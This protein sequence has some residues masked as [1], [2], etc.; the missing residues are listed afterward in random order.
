MGL[1]AIQ[2][3]E[4]LAWLQRPGCWLESARSSDQGLGLL[5][6]KDMKVWEV[7]EGFASGQEQLSEKLRPPQSLAGQ[8]LLTA[9]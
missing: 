5:K 6:P 2:A 4:V 7:R 3:H 1:L 9:C 8:A